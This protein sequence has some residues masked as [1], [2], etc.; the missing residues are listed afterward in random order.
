[1]P[2]DHEADSGPSFIPVRPSSQGN[3]SSLTSR[4]RRIVFRRMIRMELEHGPLSWLRRRQFVRFARDIGIPRREARGIIAD[5]ERYRARI[6]S[7]TDEAPADSPSQSRSE[8]I[9]LCVKL[10][11]AV[12]AGILI[13]ALLW[14]AFTT[15]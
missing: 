14:L 8:L 5:A 1:M 4:E 9:W 11:A 10:T 12:T 7:P 6:D 2:D 3:R 15:R 13:E